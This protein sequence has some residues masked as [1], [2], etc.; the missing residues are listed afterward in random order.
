MKDAEIAK[1]GWRERS[2]GLQHPQTLSGGWAYSVRSNAK[3]VR[4]KAF[5]IKVD[6]RVEAHIVA[7]ACS[8]TPN[9]EAQW[10]LSMLADERGQ[11][12]AGGEHLAREGASS[13]KKTR[14]GLT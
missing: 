1:S 3:P 13:F 4:T 5:P 10:T 12:R 6:G 9:Q 7:L 11:A 2:D 8:D 14:S